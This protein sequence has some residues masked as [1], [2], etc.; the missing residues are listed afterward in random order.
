MDF[1]RNLLWG[2]ALPFKAARLILSRKSLIG[3]SIV[4]IAIAALLYSFAI[5]H[6][7]EWARIQIYNRLLGWNLDPRAPRSTRLRM[8][9]TEA[10]APG[11]RRSPGG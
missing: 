9:V 1:I 5:S 7:H 8:R 6:V 2:A 4:P 3:L 11:V 10:L